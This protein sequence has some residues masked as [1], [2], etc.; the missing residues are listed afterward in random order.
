M[1]NRFMPGMP[2]VE[3]IVN[4]KSLSAHAADVYRRVGHLVYDTPK[5]FARDAAD[6][7]G[8]K[9]DMTEAEINE[10]RREIAAAI[11]PDSEESGD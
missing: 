2:T 8:H 3:L 1:S 5:A 6:Y 10:L 7:I 11:A 4:D 9:R